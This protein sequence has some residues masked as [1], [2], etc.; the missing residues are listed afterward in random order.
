MKKLS[1]EESAQLGREAR[2]LSPRSAHGEWAA[3]ADRRDP[4]LLLEQQDETRVPFLVPIRHGRMRVSP[5]TFYRGTAR[6]MA[7]DLASTPTS[8]LTVQL[9]GDA[10]LSNF[11]AYASPERQLVFDA[12]DFDE[13]LRGPWEWDLKRLATSFM[14]AGG[15]LGF[16]RRA[17]A[18]ITSRCTQAYRR[19]M[20]EFARTGYVKL[21]YDYVSSDEVRAAAESDPAEL[22]KRLNRFE[23]RARSKTSLQALS[24]LTV[25]VD[26]H[27][28]IRSDPP[29]LF[30]LRDLPAEYDAPA[31]EAAALEAFDN[32]KSTLSDDRHWLLNR[33]TPVDVGIKVVGVGSVGTRC[34][35][36]LLEGRDRDDPLFLQAKEATAS[37]L[38]E[39]LE[40][41]PYRNHGRRV[42]EGQRM[43]QA[44][45]DIFLGWTEGRE[46]V[47]FYL[48]QL[49]DWKGSVEVETVTPNQLRFYAS[50]CGRTMARGHA[51]SGDPVAISSYMGKSDNLDRA[52]TAFA[53]AY[54]VQNLE[55]Y[56]RF[57]SAIDDGRLEVAED[58]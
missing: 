25:P 37:V 27:H 48:R 45:S 51:R 19:A 36:I 29:V 9:G 4:V 30:P 44:Q 39:H 31:L 54:A 10:H 42:V 14:I 2:R 3:P 21:W 1:V 7:A 58:A 57:N 13:T 56:Q 50:L 55:D 38:E 33:Y 53:E 15:H 40:P 17:C 5:F 24:K 18:E 43:I 41:S 12:N 26:G 35:I 23:R 46:G 34:L 8:G 32:Y 28:Q 16:P 49:R 22:T 11:G 20:G 47:H 52:V 6:I